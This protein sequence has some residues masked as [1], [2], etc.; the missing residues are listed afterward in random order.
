MSNPEEI[1]CAAI[2]KKVRAEIY[3]FVQEACDVSEVEIYGVDQSVAGSMSPYTID[4]HDHHLGFTLRPKGSTDEDR[5]FLG[6]RLRQESFQP[7]I[8][9]W[10]THTQMRDFRPCELTEEV[11]DCLHACINHTISR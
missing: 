5:K 6:I 11:K 1:T 4:G 2:W 9:I 3:N 7:F 8:T 10:G